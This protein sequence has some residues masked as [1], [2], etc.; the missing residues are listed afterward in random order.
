M[1]AVRGQV[2]ALLRPLRVPAFRRLWTAQLVSEVGDWSARLVLSLVVYGRSGSVVLT[3][4]VTT[5]LLIPWLGPGQ[6]L[7]GLL[8][9]W[10]RRRVMV[11]A[12]LVRAAAFLVALVPLPVPLLLLTVFGAGLAT[13]P[14][15]AARSALRPEIVPTPLVSPAIALSSITQDLSVVAGYAAGGLLVALLGP[16]P[17]LLVNAAS[18]AVSAVLLAGLPDAGPPGCSGST[19]AALRDGVRALRDDPFIVRA[20]LLVTAAMFTATSLTALAA[21]LVMQLLG[22]GPSRVGLLVGLAAAV[23]LV[24]TAAVPAADDPV[25]LLRWAAT[26]TTLGAAC[27]LLSLTL[28]SFG[29]GTTTGLAIAVFAGIGL[30]FAVIAPANVVVTPRLPAPIRASAVSVLMG[31]LVATEAIGAAAAGLAASIVGVLPVGIALAVPALVLGGLALHT[32][33]HPAAGTHETDHTST[34][35]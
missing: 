34:Q 27:V 20:V 23:S 22:A 26:F 10:P 28:I 2:V 3:G 4:L 14:F 8:E 6:L 9:R 1:R 31:A 25:L 11:A 19:T 13:P 35:H 29:L 32:R 16:R 12:D 18:F 21:P 24:V 5:V 7:T 30:L 15:E 17:A 33:P